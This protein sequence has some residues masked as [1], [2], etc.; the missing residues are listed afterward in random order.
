MDALAVGV[1]TDGTNACGKILKVTGPFVMI[2]ELGVSVI[3]SAA[4]DADENGKVSARQS[5]TVMNQALIIDALLHVDEE[6]CG[7][8]GKAG[9]RSD[10]SREAMLGVFW[11]E[12][13]RF[14]NAGLGP[15]A[16][17]IK[18]GREPT[19]A[20]ARCAYAI[21]LNPA[22]LQ[23]RQQSDRCTDRISLLKRN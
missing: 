14:G 11:R 7:S 1:E 15:C 6:I 10:H 22:T 12:G 23:P 21:H 8:A 17:M 4:M 18:C 2:R 20:A 5:M 19:F 3:N 13:L 9:F 16:A